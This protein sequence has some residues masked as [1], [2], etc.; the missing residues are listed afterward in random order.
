[1][2]ATMDKAG[3]VIIPQPLRE[4]VGLRPGAVEVVVDGAGIRI[5]AIS[6][7]SV[8]ERDGRLVIPAAG[9]VVD[10]ETVRSLRDA[11]PR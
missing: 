8:E 4:Q 9:A 5:E 7:E 3:L 1:M 2:H 6:E 11:D 10:D